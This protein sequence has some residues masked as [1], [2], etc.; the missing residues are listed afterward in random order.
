MPDSNGCS[1]K[2]QDELITADSKTGFPAY[3]NKNN[4]QTLLDSWGPFCAR[5]VFIVGVNGSGSDLSVA[6]D[7]PVQGA[8]QQMRNS[9]PMLTFLNC[10]IC[11]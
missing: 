9:K 5:S 2:H 3:N 6:Q 10:F 11:L 4:T 7:G 1:W 8:P